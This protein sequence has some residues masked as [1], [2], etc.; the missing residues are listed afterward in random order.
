LKEKVECL[1]LYA[2]K[3]FKAIMQAKALDRPGGLSMNEIVKT[4][5]LD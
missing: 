2:P 3:L 5:L 1:Q 4:S